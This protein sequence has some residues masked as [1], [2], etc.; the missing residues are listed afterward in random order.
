MAAA[1]QRGPLLRCRLHH[2]SRRLVTPSWAAASGHLAASPCRLGPPLPPGCVRTARLFGESPA[3]AAAGWHKLRVR[4]LG[5]P[6]AGMAC[7]RGRFSPPPQPPPVAVA[8]SAVA[9]HSEWPPGCAAISARPTSTCAP[10]SSW[11][12]RSV[13][14]G[15]ASGD[16]LRRAAALWREVRDAGRMDVGR[17]RATVGSC[18]SECGLCDGEGPRGGGCLCWSGTYTRGCGLY[19]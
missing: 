4:G 3:F 17:A 8:W 2:L 16:R 18:T 15:L 9:G 6:P 11:R 13:S 1:R 7:Q 10:P 14:A 12:G 5:R 19:F